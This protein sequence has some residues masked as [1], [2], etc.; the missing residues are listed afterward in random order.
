MAS[1][2]AGPARS[3]A[4]PG[5]GM[6][7]PRAVPVDA[8]TRLGIVAAVFLLFA[9]SGGLLWLL[10]YNYEGLQGSALTKIHPST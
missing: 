6:A 5:Y 3:A 8:L 2:L 10:G 9:V 7:G 4:A 1:I